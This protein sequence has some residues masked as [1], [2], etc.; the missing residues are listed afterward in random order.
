MVGIHSPEYAFE[1]DAGNVAAG[2]RD[3]G[4]TYPVALD[5]TL[6]T[7]TNYRNRYWPAHYLIDAEGQ[8]ATSRLARATTRLRRN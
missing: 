5:N 1:K 8:F 3:F 2:A 4:I 6:S 7:W